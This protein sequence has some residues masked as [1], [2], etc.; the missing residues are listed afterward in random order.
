[1]EL[2]PDGGDASVY[3]ITWYSVQEGIA[4]AE[5]KQV[6]AE[7]TEIGSFR[8]L[9]LLSLEVIDPQPQGGPVPDLLE[10]APGGYPALKVY[11]GKKPKEGTVQQGT[12]WVT[13]YPDPSAPVSRMNLSVL[14][15]MPTLDPPGSTRRVSWFTMGAVFL[16][17]AGLLLLFLRPAG[18]VPDSA[19]G[20]SRHG[21][22]WLA[23]A[24]VYLFA[25]AAAAS[26]SPCGCWLNVAC[27]IPMWDNGDPGGFYL[28]NIFT[29]F[30]R[31]ED[32]SW[33]MHP[34]LTL[35]LVLYVVVRAC[36]LLYQLFGGVL[37]LEV[38]AARN[39]TTLFYVCTLTQAALHLL[40]FYLLYHFARKL[41]DDSQVALLAVL[42]YATAFPTVYFLGRISPEPILVILF[43]L[44]VLSL[45]AAL[46]ALGEGKTFRAYISA[47]LSGLC[48]VAALYTKVFLALPLVPLVFLQ[49]LLQ[50]QRPDE[51]LRARLRQRPPLAAW[52]V[53]CSALFFVAG[54][55]MLSW[56][57]FL[58][59]WILYMPNT[60]WGG[61]AAQADTSAPDIPDE[62]WFARYT[63]SARNI[64]P[65]M[66]GKL[67]DF[68]P[69][70]FSAT[71]T[72]IFTLT[73]AVFLVCSLVG[74]VWHWRAHRE[75]RGRVF[76]LVLFGLLLGPLWLYRASWHYLLLHLPVLAVFFAYFL[77][78]SIKGLTSGQVPQWAAFR[79][80]AL[81]VLMVHSTALLF[82]LDAKRNDIET[83][84]HKVW[85]FHLALQG[86][87]PGERVAVV[88]QPGTEAPPTWAILGMYVQYVPEGHPVQKVFADQF[89]IIGPDQLLSHAFLAEHNVRMVVDYTDAGAT[90][91][92]RLEPASSP[93]DNGSD[94]R[95]LVL[96]VREAVAATVPAG[97]TVLVVSKG[98]D[99]LLALPGRKGWHFPRDEN[100]DY[101]GYD[102]ERD[103]AIP[104]LEALRAKGGQFLVF[105]ETTFWWLDYYKEF[106]QHL[107]SRYRRIHSDRDCIIYQLSG[108]K[109]G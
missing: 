22:F 105:P 99:D 102:P 44:T 4:T 86:T 89:V 107:E 56:E 78:Q 50:K 3:E 101:L 109:D 73:E 40:S 58:G 52:F 20:Q 1:M 53:L 43:L 16:A 72:G 63:H 59:E 37:P 31:G 87:Q 69:N 85:P 49:L 62:S 11:E 21:R 18:P 13:K 39:V 81:A 24:A 106:K 66:W 51:P 42:A 108:T 98:D 65:V 46:Q 71:F 30:G 23:L 48:A 33:K 9:A 32:L 27:N 38:F 19:G 104:Q 28:G 26:W 14:E 79:A 29:F 76:W 64:G 75:Q 8:E 83:F 7:M 47:A 70:Y 82:Y 17:G 45:W 74:L 103:Q 68:V 93:G 96:R 61:S 15:Q 35:Q 60:A 91:V 57:K 97:A 2:L 88:V 100:G 41:L 6:A 25:A 34:G 10:I 84:R 67:T 54:G 92:R 90:A 95:A 36:Y 5:G 77:S 80:A 94:Y 12:A 55:Q